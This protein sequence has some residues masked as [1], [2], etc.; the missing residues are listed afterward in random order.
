MVKDAGFDE[1]GER[2][3]RLSAESADDIGVI[4]TL[5]QDAVCKVK[6]VQVSARRRRFSMLLYRFRWEDVENAEREKRPYERVATA[7]TIDDVQNTRA[8][9]VDPAKG[10]TVLNLLT[11]SFEAGEDGAGI[12]TLDCSDGVKIQLNVE[13]VNM[14][15]V[16]LTRPWAAGGKPQHF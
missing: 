12:V 15:L 13:C 5:V 9:G 10:E 7:L 2:A 6:N 11:M 16:D 14:R 1:G 8:A 3:L 4:A